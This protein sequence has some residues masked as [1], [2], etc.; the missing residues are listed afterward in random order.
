MMQSGEL[1]VTGHDHAIIPLRGMP[2]KVTVHFEDHIIPIPCNPHHHDELHHAV[3]RSNEH[4]SGFVL[5]ISW[6][7]SGVREVIWRVYY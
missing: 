5:R 6:R 1:T 7:V 3:H 2:A 4:H